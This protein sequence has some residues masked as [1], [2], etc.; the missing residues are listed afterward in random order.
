M[1]KRFTQQTAWKAILRGLG[2]LKNRDG[3]GIFKNLDLFRK[4]EAKST[5]SGFDHETVSGP[6]IQY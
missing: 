5:G 1:T 2:R 6:K 3:K 4:S